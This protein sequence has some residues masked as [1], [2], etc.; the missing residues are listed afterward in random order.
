LPFPGVNGL[1][2]PTPTLLVLELPTPM[3]LVPLLSRVRGGD[4]RPHDGDGAR[5]D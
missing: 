5:P 3:F 4:A 1:E 2:L